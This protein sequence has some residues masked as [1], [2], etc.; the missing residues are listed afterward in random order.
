[1]KTHPPVLTLT[2]TKS[3]PIRAN[4]FT[5][6]VAL[7]AVMSLLSISML[8]AK[9]LHVAPW[10][11]NNPA[12]GYGESPSTPYR[13]L[14]YA[15]DRTNPGDTVRIMEG[16]YNET[17]NISRSGTAQNP[18]TYINH[19]A[20][21]PLITFAGYYGVQVRASYITVDGL[22]VRG[23]SANL[24]LAGAQAAAAALIANGTFNTAYEGTG[25]LVVGTSS[26]PIRNVNVRRSEVWLC[27]ASGINARYADYV[28][29]EQNNVHENCY[30]TSYGTSGI[31][32]H[33]LKG[34]D[35]NTG[36]KTTVR[37][38]RTWGNRLYIPW[39][40]ANGGPAITDG[41]GIIVDQTNLSGYNGIVR[42]ENN[43]CYGNG[44][45]GINLTDSSRVE[46]YHNT[47]YGNAQSPEI[48]SEFIVGYGSN[49]T[50]VHN[51][52]FISTTGKKVQRIVSSTN[53]F[54]A[55]NI[56]RG[57]A[58]N[59]E[60]DVFTASDI[61]ADPRLENP[62]YSMFDLTVNST[63]A[64]NQ[65]YWTTT[66]GDFLGSPRTGVFDIGAYEY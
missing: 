19:S 56:Y 66:V 60:R 16:T 6:F 33:L 4:R 51:N 11:T 10:G 57:G 61:T 64:I 41:N 9:T 8:S 39:K 24:T 15:H 1:M 48:S 65:G 49:N 25:I 54:L 5:R 22:R 35:S 18:I 26:N 45:R 3:S 40:D 23:N 38:N 34:V 46:V 53:C 63:A 29:I 17:L 7:P 31:N 52:I 44:G 27:P 47:T 37:R 21:R 13:N 2:S 42:I 28:T 50:R 12:A 43:L 55:N 20:N 32:L 58:Y 30:Y 14:Q 59:G 36:V 62:A